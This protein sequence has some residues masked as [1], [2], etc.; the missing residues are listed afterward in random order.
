MA[1]SGIHGGD[2]VGLEM[3]TTLQ[4]AIGIVGRVSRDGIA[5]AASLR[6]D[7][8][9]NIV[10]RDRL[11]SELPGNVRAATESQLRQ[12]NIAIDVLET[13]HTI[14]ALQHDGRNDTALREE[15]SNYL[16]GVSADDAALRLIQLTTNPRYTS[17][18]AGPFGESLAARHGIDPV[19]IRRA[20]LSTVVNHGTPSQQRAAKALEQIP[21]ARRVVALARAGRDN[22]VKSL[23]RNGRVDDFDPT[24][25]G[26]ERA[27]LI[28][29]RS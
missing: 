22:T 21:A 29:E 12:A 15:V 19:A 1:L 25:P 27:R 20:A 26:H 28:R 2:P 5:T 14:N 6:A 16:S 17:I 24:R 8:V 3:Q 13:K 7:D 11:L 23:T 10:G 9:M 4:N 18:L